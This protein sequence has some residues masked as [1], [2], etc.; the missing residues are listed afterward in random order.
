[1]AALPAVSG[2]NL[3]RNGISFDPGVSLIRHFDFYLNLAYHTVIF[4]ENQMQLHNNFGPILA[5]LWRERRAYSV[6]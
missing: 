2:L 6:T 5:F 4:N 3:D 1:M